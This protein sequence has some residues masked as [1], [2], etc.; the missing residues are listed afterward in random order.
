MSFPAALLA[1]ASSGN[2]FV[3]KLL[4]VLWRYPSG[5][6]ILVLVLLVLVPLRPL[7]ELD[8]TG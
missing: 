4:G 3:G 1:R 8:V 2:P 6:M 7:P 5:T